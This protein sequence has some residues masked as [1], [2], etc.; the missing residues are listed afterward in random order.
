MA[1]TKT[2]TVYTIY[3]DEYLLDM[4]SAVYYES[5]YILVVLFFSIFCFEKY[6][7]QS[8]PIKEDG[9]PALVYAVILALFIGFRPVHPVFADTVGYARYY[10]YVYGDPFQFS[11]DVENLIFD[12]P[13]LTNTRR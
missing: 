13:I 4:I 12:I 3:N 9:K 1:S 11:T 5:V 10:A 2:I 8:S 7:R 6:R